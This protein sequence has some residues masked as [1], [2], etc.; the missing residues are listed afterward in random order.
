M[1]REM[2]LVR[3]LLFYVEENQ[4]NEPLQSGEINIDGHEEGAIGYHLKIMAGE[5]KIDAQY[6]TTFDSIS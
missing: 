3:R 2:D 5:G 4:E 6:I 1:K